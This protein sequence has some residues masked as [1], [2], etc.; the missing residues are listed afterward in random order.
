MRKL[1]TFLL[2]LGL[3]FAII[4]SPDIGQKAS[5]TDLEVHFIDVGQG[6]SI[7]IKSDDESILIDGGGRSK[8]E[9]LVNYLQDQE[10]EDLKY[11]IGTHPHEDHIGGFIEVLNNF[12]V[13]NIMLPNIASN[14]IVF[15]DLLDAIEREDLKIKKPIVLDKIDI[16]QGQITI[17]A[18]NSERYSNTNNYSIVTRLVHGRNKFIFTGDAEKQSEDEILKAHRSLL[19]AHVLKLGHHG[20]NTSTNKE[21]LEVVEPEAAIISVGHGNS[22]QH[23]DDDVI[24]KLKSKNV[25]IYRTDRDGDIIVYSDGEDLKFKSER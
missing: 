1:I 8:S 2:S 3:L 17:L 15:E 23:P 19:K 12:N 16:G 18:P 5:E 9:L 22:Y 25:N 14:T 21:F 13:E 7:L 6:D 11:V 4:Y 10:V 20:S 24:E